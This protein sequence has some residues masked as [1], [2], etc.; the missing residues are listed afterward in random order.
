MFMSIN[1]LKIV[2][3]ST[4]IAAL[5]LSASLAYADPEAEALQARIDA[6][7]ARDRAEEIDREEASQAAVDGASAPELG[8]EERAADD[9]LEGE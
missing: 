4:L 2:T 9:E 1:K 7:E 5:P 3:L 6:G 8:A